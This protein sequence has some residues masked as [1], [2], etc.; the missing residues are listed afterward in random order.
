MTQEQALYWIQ[1]CRQQ[2]Y[3]INKIGDKRKKLVFLSEQYDKLHLLV[4]A[5]NGDIT[6]IGIP[7]DE[8]WV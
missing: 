6:F 8:T 5:V 3:D 7:H 1:A 4:R 2:L